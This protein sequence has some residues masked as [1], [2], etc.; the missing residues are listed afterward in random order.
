VESEFNTKSKSISWFSSSKSSS[1][2]S[3]LI[4]ILDDLFRIW[5][6]TCFSY[7]SSFRWKA[8]L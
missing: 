6:K 3:Y 8:S 7:S 4:E 1:S 5:F 2:S